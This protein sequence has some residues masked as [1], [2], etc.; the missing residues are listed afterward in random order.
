MPSKLLILQGGLYTI[1]AALTPVPVFLAGSEPITTRALWG[2]VVS[3]LLAG[4]TALKAFLSTN[5]AESK[6]SQPDAPPP[7]LPPW[8]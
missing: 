8:Q 1:I 5:F 2:L 6:E 7:A 4:A 3:S